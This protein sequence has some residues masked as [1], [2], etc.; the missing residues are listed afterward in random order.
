MFNQNEKYQFLYLQ[1]QNI[2]VTDKREDLAMEAKH[3]KAILNSL[4]Y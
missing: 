1:R 2:E 4:K 3:A